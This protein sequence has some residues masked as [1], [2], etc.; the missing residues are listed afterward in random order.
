MK[1][2]T[3]LAVS[4]ILA[5]GCSS[6][7]QALL[8]YD[9]AA[10]L[11]GEIWRILTGNLVHFSGP[12]LF[13]D[14]LVLGAAGVVIERRGYA[15]FGWLCLLSSVAIG[16]VLLASQPSVLVYGGASGVATAAVV[17]LAMNGLTEKKEMWIW[18]MLSVVTLMLVA[19][20]IATEFATEHSFFVDAASQGLTLCPVSHLIGALAAFLCMPGRKAAPGRHHSGHHAGDL[21]GGT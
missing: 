13:W 9:R 7:A 15:H 19:T 1:K 6:S 21:M 5:I 8:V 11:N 2:V 12:H 18:R 16:L 20:K 4:L 14:T 17:Y 3:L 10:I